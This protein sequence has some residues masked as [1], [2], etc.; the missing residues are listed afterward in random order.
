MTEELVNA[1]HM[2][3]CECLRKQLVVVNAEIQPHCTT[4][5]V[6]FFIIIH[7]LVVYVYEPYV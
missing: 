4:R 2:R 6:M 7:Q 3:V 5:S 1:E